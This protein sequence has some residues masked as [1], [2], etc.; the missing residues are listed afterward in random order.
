MTSAGNFDQPHLVAEFVLQRMNIGHRCDRVLGSIVLF[1]GVMGD[2]KSWPDLSARVITIGAS[3]CF[4]ASWSVRPPSGAHPTRTVARCYEPALL[5]QPV[6]FA[7]R[8]RAG[9]CTC[10]RLCQ[11][12]V[13][14]GGTEARQ[15]PPRATPAASAPTVAEQQTARDAL[16]HQIADLQR[17]ASDLQNQIAQR[18]RDI[19]AKR[20]EMDGLRQGFEAM[21]AETDTLRQQRQT[22]Q[23]ALARSKA[24]QTQM[25][26]TNAPRRPPAP[27]RPLCHRRR[28]RPELTKRPPGTHKQTDR[29]HREEPVAEIRQKRSELALRHRSLGVG[30]HLISVGGAKGAGRGAFVAWKLHDKPCRNGA[31][32]GN[33]DDKV[34]R[35]CWSATCASRRTAT[36]R[37][38]TCSATPFSPLVSMS[39]TYSTTGRAAAAV[40]APAWPKHSRLFDNGNGAPSAPPAAASRG[41]ASL[42]PFLDQR[43]LELCK[44]TE[45]VEQ[46]LALWR[47]RVDLLSQ[48][49]ECDAALLEPCYRVQEMRQ[50][51]A[52][53]IQLPDHQAVAGTQ[54]NIERTSRSGRN[55]SAGFASVQT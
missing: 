22:E 25:A 6:H 26:T 31:L 46:Q 18:S 51:T 10:K 9:Q 55:G 54:W 4:H 41:K 32:C 49:S 3:L 39:V 30:N 48:R 45:N 42:H 34:F 14:V 21:R 24:Q 36:A 52:E 19:E 11:S 17:Q 50:R 37:S 16:Q 13:I 44:R 15:A 29:E 27:P 7:R 1:A 2:L 23:D 33:P 5:H 35:T 43:P 8:D 47:G 28:L 40:I 53:P 38:W 12:R 20:A